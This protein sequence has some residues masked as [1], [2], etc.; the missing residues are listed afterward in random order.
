MW[1]RTP[2]RRGARPLRSAARHRRLNMSGPSRR[3]CFFS[4]MPRKKL[5]HE[6]APAR[7]RWNSRP[8]MRQADARHRRRHHV[9]EGA[10]HAARRRAEVDADEDRR[11]HVERELLVGAEGRAA[12]QRAAPS[13]ARCA[14]DHR[15]HALGVVAQ[16]RP[17]EGLVHDLAVVLVVG[18]VPQQQ[19]V[20]E[21]APHDLRPGLLR[22]RR[23]DRDRAA[24]RGSRRGRTGSPCGRRRPAASPRRRGA[25]TAGAAASACRRGRRRPSRSSGACRRSP[26]RGISE[27]G[28]HVAGAAAHRPSPAPLGRSPGVHSLIPLR[29]STRRR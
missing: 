29:R 19:A 15:V 23:S 3:A 6:L 21:D 20:R 5:E 4:S 11:R 12:G 27:G 28:S 17:R 13:S 1:S 7:P 25:R 18:A 24:R 26:G 2:R 8:G 16:R 22:A 10:V 14:R 9:L